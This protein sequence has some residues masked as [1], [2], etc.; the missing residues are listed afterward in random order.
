MA[1][2]VGF[3]I[4]RW[5]LLKILWP[6]NEVYVVP[7]ADETVAKVRASHLTILG[8]ISFLLLKLCGKK[9]E[10]KTEQSSEEAPSREEIDELINNI[11]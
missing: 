7:S 11:E 1:I 3:F 10:A 4:V 8:L 2:L 6:G 9:K 5:L